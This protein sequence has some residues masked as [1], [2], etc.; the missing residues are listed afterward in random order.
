MGSHVIPD[1]SRPCVLCGAPSIGPRILG[2]SLDIYAT[3]RRCRNCFR[4]QTTSRRELHLEAEIER[5]CG[6]LAE[7]E[8][9]T[10]RW[11]AKRDPTRQREGES[12]TDYFLR[13]VVVE[14]LRL[15]G[16]AL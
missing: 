15:K 4:I 7:A 16:G 8:A 9:Q 6:L 12:F 14:Y 13:M 2:Q 3:E 5:L 11:L 10:P 1:P